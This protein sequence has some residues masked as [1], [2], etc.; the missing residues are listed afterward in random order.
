MNV[1]LENI[2]KT[3]VKFIISADDKDLSPIKKEALEALRPRVK[4][5]GFRNGKAPDAIV[6]KEIGDDAIQSEVLDGALRHFYAKAAVEHKVRVV[7]NPE[8][9]VS[10]FVPYTTLEFEIE[11]DVF[12]EVELPDYKK[13]KL[14]RDPVKVAEEEIKAVLDDLATRQADR[15]AA[16]RAAKNGD[17]VSI[18]FKGIKDGKPLPGGSGN[19]YPLILGSN[20]FIPGFEKEII[21]LKVDDKKKFDIT[22]P[23][24]YGEISLQGKKVTFDV[25]IK[26]IKELKKPKIDDAFATTV[27]PFEKLSELK[28]DIKKQLESDQEQRDQRE[29]ETAL[30]KQIV[31]KSILELPKSLVES[32]KDEVKKSM[33]A[34][35][36]EKII[37]EQ[38]CERVKTGLVL[39]EISK[40]ENI[41]VTQ[42][43]V[44]ARINLLRSQYPDPKMQ[45]Q[46]ESEEVRLDIEHQLRTE[47]TIDKLLKYTDKIKKD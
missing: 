23:K 43:D 8:V 40:Q 29:A 41:E 37:E 26:G 13:M 27:G 3:R 6:E 42:L 10:K 5:Q 38:A 45:E 20:S 1:K 35:T 25:T 18:D 12:P 44:D 32:Q 33:P 7:G 4:A 9:K 30:I 22:F 28:A 15:V 16:E 19:N 47:K 34:E 46:L 17:E 21:G 2:S 39:A 24:D 36:D 31:E 11:V 14:S